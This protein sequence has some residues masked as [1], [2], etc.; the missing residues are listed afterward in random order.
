MTSRIPLKELA[1]LCP[2]QDGFTSLVVLGRAEVTKAEAILDR[3]SP[4]M[5]RLLGG[6]AQLH[7]G[8]WLWIRW[9]EDGTVE[10]VQELVQL[11]R[12]P[13]RP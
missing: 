2:E 3:L 6:A 9:P 4:A 5:Q 11:K 7:D 13:R 12:R 10:D 8:R 1:S